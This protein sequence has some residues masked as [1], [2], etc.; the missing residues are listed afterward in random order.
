MEFDRD[1]FDNEVNASIENTD[2]AD[3]NNTGSNDEP[4]DIDSIIRRHCKGGGRYS[5]K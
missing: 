2:N 4:R 3:I 5:K 1:E